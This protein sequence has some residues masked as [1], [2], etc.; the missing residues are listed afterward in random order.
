MQNK[1]RL[2]VADTG[3]AQ[4]LPD[5]LLAEI[6]AERLTLAM[7]ALTHEMA[8]HE[9][10]GAA[11]M[12]AYLMTASLRAPLIHEDAEIYV[13][14]TAKLMQRQG[15]ELE[16]FMQAKLEQGLS[17]DE[18]RRLTHLKTEIFRQR[19]GDI[20][21]PLLTVLRELKK[22]AAERKS[23]PQLNLF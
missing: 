4:D 7:A 19:G 3:W 17:A 5:W 21:S 22:S 11:E 2:V 23:G 15:K 1:N 8:D 16:D 18:N 10:V 6:A 14:L 12:V 20:E 9:K 13:Y